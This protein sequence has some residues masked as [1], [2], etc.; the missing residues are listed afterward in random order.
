MRTIERGHRGT[1]ELT[2][3]TD[4]IS[5]PVKAFARAFSRISS[6]S[7]NAS[8]SKQRGTTSQPC[9]REHVV[10]GLLSRTRVS[11]CFS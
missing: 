3:D 10:R 5:S 7:M 1:A 8:W 4:G 11:F 9:R 6:T 2:A